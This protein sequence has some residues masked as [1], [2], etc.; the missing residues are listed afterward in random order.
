MGPTPDP[1][2]LLTY[3]QEPPGAC[4]QQ[5]RTDGKL[6]LMAP[7]ES[8]TGDGQSPAQEALHR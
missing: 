2:S 3:G 4:P 1:C 6:A 8:A 7:Q 5:E